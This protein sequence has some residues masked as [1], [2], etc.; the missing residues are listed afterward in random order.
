LPTAWALAPRRLQ[1]NVFD[2][3]A[4][5]RLLLDTDMVARWAA[6]LQVA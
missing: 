6:A 2:S 1:D 3:G 4:R 5:P